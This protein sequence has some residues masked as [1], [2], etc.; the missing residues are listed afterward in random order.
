MQILLLRAKLGNRAGPTSVLIDGEFALAPACPQA[1]T[2]QRNLTRGK[3][4]RQ[5]RMAQASISS[6]FRRT[7]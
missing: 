3:V 5:T 2:C 6:R 4:M 7:R 1:E